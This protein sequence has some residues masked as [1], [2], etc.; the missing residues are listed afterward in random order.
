MFSKKSGEGCK[1]LTL[2]SVLSIENRFFVK[3]V[4][5][6][7]SQVS[8][9]VTLLGHYVEAAS[10]DDLAAFKTSGFVPA[11]IS[12]TPPQPL[13]DASIEW[14]DRGPATGEVVV[15][16]KGLPKA[17]HYDLHYGLVANAGTPPATWTTL[18]LP[19][20]KKLT[21]SNLTPG[22]LCVSS[23]CDGPFGLHQLE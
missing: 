9:Q 3:A 18:N 16:I 14:I 5:N 11:P 15:K 13:P 17:I 1:V 2:S 7:V 6:R 12:R 4:S 21:I 19:G 22:D 8:C 20:S 23:P 10:N